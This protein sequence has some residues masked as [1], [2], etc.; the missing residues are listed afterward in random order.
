MQNQGLL[1]QFF[2]LGQVTVGS[3]TL[4]KSHSSC[5]GQKCEL[6]VV[7]KTFAHLAPSLIVFHLSFGHSANFFSLQLHLST[8]FKVL[9]TFQALITA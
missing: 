7:Q 9:Q 4:P 6:G 8:V 3:Q 5:T 2:I 1:P